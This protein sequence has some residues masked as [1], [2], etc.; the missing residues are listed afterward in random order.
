MNNYS[1]LQI[2]FF[3]GDE[4]FKE[5]TK[6]D[7]YPQVAARKLE[8]RYV[9]GLMKNAVDLTVLSFFP[10]SNFPG[11]KK[12]WFP[13]AKNIMQ[14]VSNYSYPFINIIGLKHV[15]R[16]FSCVSFLI[17]WHLH[18]D[19]KRKIII[20]YSAHSPFLLAALLFKVF[21]RT[22]L[23]VIVPDLPRHMNF[24]KKKSALWHFLK[25]L[26]ASF[27]DR[28]IACTSGV[29][30]VSKNMVVENENWLK[31]PYVVIEGMIDAASAPIVRVQLQQKVFMYTGGLNAEY[32]VQEILSAFEILLA[33]R[34]D[35]ELWLC[36][37]G[38]LVSE[39]ERLAEKY[40]QIRYFG[41]VTQ[42]EI[43]QLMTQVFCLLNC[44]NPDDAFVK[45]SFP[46][47]LL[48][49]LSSGIPVLTTKLPG[50]PAEYDEV[51]NY[52]DG[53]A[54]GTIADGIRN[55]LLCDESQL[56][57][58]ARRGRALVLNKKNSQ[59]QV[60]KFL[61]LIFSKDNKYV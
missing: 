49:Y 45:Y 55:T 53:G 22:P 10:A 30:V 48:E 25:K 18:R 20:I 36:G 47:K 32:G 23:Y 13:F 51:L 41:Y 16:F 12:I 57:D 54:A 42:G 17:K 52:L 44:R 37:S 26:D 5:N 15:S 61:N 21:L 3:V 29:S 8:G 34:T 2:G 60:L 7:V 14:G 19:H 39:I 59:A 27:I 33:E 35:I 46:S 43:E 38:E 4:D 9:D 50:V 40:P 31:L 28:L 24:G 1:F 11:N 6:A 58:K 56:Q